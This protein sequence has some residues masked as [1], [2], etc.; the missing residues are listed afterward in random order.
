MP[1]GQDFTVKTKTC[2]RKTLKTRCKISDKEAIRP[3]FLLL[4]IFIIMQITESQLRQAVKT[5]LK[6]EVYGTIATVYHG[7]RQPPEEFIKVFENESGLV[8]WE[9]GKG[10]GS[11]YGHGLYA[12]WQKTN[13]ST[14]NGSYGN[15]IYKFK[16]NLYGFVIFD[17]E[18]CRRV[19]GS[20]I[21]PLEQ[22]KRLG[23]KHLI[24]RLTEEEKNL[25]SEA[26]PN[27][28]L[29]SEYAL[30]TFRSLIG[31]V[32]GIVFWG[33]NDG[34][35]VIAYDPNVVTPIGYAKLIDAKQNH[36]KFWSSEE[37]THSL[38]RSAQAGT[39]ADP[40]RL[41]S[42]PSKIT[43]KEVI[44]IAPKLSK[45]NLIR[46]LLTIDD[47]RTYEID[48]IKDKVIKSKILSSLF[49]IKKHR[50]I[51]ANKTTSPELLAKLAEDD[52]PAV[53][54]NVALNDLTPQEVLMKLTAD[55]DLNVRESVAFKSTSPEVL[56]KLVGDSNSHVRKNVASNRSA[57]PEA[58]E[59][60]AEDKSQDVKQMVAWNTSTPPELLAKLADDW[61]PIIKNNIV[62]NT[63][64]P[65][66]LLV[67]LASDSNQIVRQ[68]VAR[69][70]K[71]PLEVLMKLA[72]DDNNFVKSAAKQELK[73]RGVQEQRLRH[74]LKSILIN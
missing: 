6:E 38:S 62:W 41:Q 34:P 13:H 47:I 49:N 45:K 36:W 48:Q 61:D 35:V 26:L 14:F 68:N 7:S 51:I 39:F 72:E 73:N 2:F 1:T 65:L 3:P 66:E 63:S 18:V 22:L 23:K 31:N 52:D 24:N 4:I 54:N 44:K 74:L 46:L 15:W 8:G 58:L 21:T 71:V 40:K 53:R 27:Q 56:I 59:K 30:R 70:D 10:A 42:S 5:L 19:Y 50:H 20:S 9:T 37:M 67:K 43:F 55:V 32:N 28:N 60:L 16:I 11:M 57:P 33:S 29:S 69:N 12:V 64:T 17:K 25:L